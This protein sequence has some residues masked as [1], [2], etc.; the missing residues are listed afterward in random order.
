[1]GRFKGSG[2]LNVFKVVP[3]SLS[4]KIREIDLGKEI[5]FEGSKRTFQDFSVPSLSQMVFFDSKRKRI[6]SSINETDSL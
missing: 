1:M 5:I 4:H 2:K 6:D 3:I